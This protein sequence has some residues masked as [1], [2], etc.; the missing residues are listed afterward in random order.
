MQ[1]GASVTRRY[2]ATL[3]IMCHSSMCHSALAHRMASRTC[4]FE[5]IFVNMSQN[6]GVSRRRLAARNCGEDLR[7]GNSAKNCGETNLQR[8]VR[9]IA[10]IF[11]NA[12]RKQIYENLGEKVVNPGRKHFRSQSSKARIPHPKFPGPFCV[13]EPQKNRPCA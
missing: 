5:C 1:V 10:E 9:E 12:L 6:T 4:M 13:A 2:A 3:G 8:I 7:R 11:D